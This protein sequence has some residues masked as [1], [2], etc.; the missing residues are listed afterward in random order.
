MLMAVI[1][2]KALQN[3]VMFAFS[4]RFSKS[5]NDLLTLQKL[6]RKKKLWLTR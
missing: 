5:R 6:K 2:D 4:F 3:P 1:G